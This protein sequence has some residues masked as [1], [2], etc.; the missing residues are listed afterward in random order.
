MLFIDRAAS[1]WMAVSQPAIHKYQGN[2]LAEA[3]IA[4]HK[5]STRRA[6]TILQ[7]IAQLD[8]FGHG[9]LSQPQNGRPSRTRVCSR[10]EVRSPL[11]MQAPDCA[12]GLQVDH[13]S[14]P[15]NDEFVEIVELRIDEPQLGIFPPL[16]CK[17][18]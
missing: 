10:L 17:L 13:L 15:S 5:Y 7:R 6:T 8:R 16:F 12:L 3:A 14:V 2:S 18:N 11:M 9:S 4:P 1:V